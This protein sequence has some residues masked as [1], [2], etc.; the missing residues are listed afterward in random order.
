MRR[1]YSAF[2]LSVVGFVSSVAEATFI[3]PPDP[4]TASAQPFP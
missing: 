1:W 4:D 2:L 3:V